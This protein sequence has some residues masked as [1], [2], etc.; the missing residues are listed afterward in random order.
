M[1]EEA[2]VGMIGFQ[3]DAGSVLTDAASERGTQ[4]SRGFG[5]ALP[6]LT[7]LLAAPLLAVALFAFL[8]LVALGLAL[9][10]FG[11][12]LCRLGRHAPQQTHRCGEGPGDGGDQSAAVRAGLNQGASDGIEPVSVHSWVPRTR[13]R[14][15]VEARRQ[16]GA[17]SH[18]R[19]WCC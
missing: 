8:T 2:T 14:A 17:E 15:A 10:G 5:L 3:V 1:A 7:A 18:R 9:A 4:G 6:G 19:L 12:R 16:G 11:L 13:L